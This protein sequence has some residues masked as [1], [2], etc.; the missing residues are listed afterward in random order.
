M[1]L[2]FCPLVSSG[3]AAVYV[4]HKNLL[5]QIKDTFQLPQMAWGPSVGPRMHCG[6]FN[7]LVSIGKS[8]KDCNKRPS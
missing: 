2:G 8:P 3:L 7:K 4:H 6:F 1:L 5:M